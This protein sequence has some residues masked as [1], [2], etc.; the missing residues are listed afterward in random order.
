MRTRNQTFTAPAFAFVVLTHQFQQP[1][2]GRVDMRRQFR[3]LVLQ[4]L[5]VLAALVSLSEVGGFEGAGR[6][7]AACR[8]HHNNLEIDTIQI[9]S[10]I[11]D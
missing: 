3:D 11:D 7:C 10:I 1:E 2:H 9:Y 4:V 8:N 5:D 6:V